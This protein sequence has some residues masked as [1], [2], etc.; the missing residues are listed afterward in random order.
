VFQLNGKKY[1]QAGQVV[2]DATFTA[3]RPFP[4]A[5]TPDA[6]VATGQR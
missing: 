1:E 4:V 5:F 2:G 6:L 3:R